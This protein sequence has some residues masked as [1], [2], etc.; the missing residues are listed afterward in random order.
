VGGTN[1]LLTLDTTNA[2][3]AAAQLGT[4][5][6]IRRPGGFDT[7]DNQ[8]VP[9]LTAGV[10]VPSYPT[11]TGLQIALSASIAGGW[12]YPLTL[13]PLP[14]QGV[15]IEVDIADQST[16]VEVMVMPIARFGGG[17]VT[18]FVMQHYGALQQID[19]RLVDLAPPPPTPPP[20]QLGTVDAVSWNMNTQ[21]P[22]TPNFNRAINKVRYEVVA[23][24]PQTPARWRVSGFARNTAGNG[25]SE[26]IAS[27]VS[28]V[29]S[30]VVAWDGLPQPTLGLGLFRLSVGTGSIL[31]TR[32]QVFP[33]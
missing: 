2:V 27:G 17:T 28:G 12:I 3:T 32:V 8:G 19:S 13:P 33:L 25:I 29:S 16:D 7:W 5:A 1:A 31:L 24:G 30:P 9:T 10:S 18:G 22:T 14:P 26:S 20:P 15:A 23:D 6:F 4:P 21:F 11:Q